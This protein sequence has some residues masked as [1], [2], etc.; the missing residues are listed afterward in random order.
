MKKQSSELSDREL[1]KAADRTWR[2]Y[3]AISEE[4]NRRERV[5]RYGTAEPDLKA[6]NVSVWMDSIDL[7]VK[8][9][10]GD[11]AEQIV[12]KSLWVCNDNPEQITIDDW[13]G[14]SMA[15]EEAELELE[16]TAD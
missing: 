1:E 9:Q 7:T 10:S 2:T 3:L 14:I 16:D 13:P 6:Y 12:R 4:Q 8:T 5:A 15:I 11:D